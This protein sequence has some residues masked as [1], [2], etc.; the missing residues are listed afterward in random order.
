MDRKTLIGKLK[1]RGELWNEPGGGEWGTEECW[2]AFIR[3]ALE[4]WNGFCAFLTEEA[5]AREMV[6]LS[7]VIFELVEKLGKERVLVPFKKVAEKY[8]TEAEKYNILR[9]ISC[10]ESDDY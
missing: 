10:I 6:Y 3:I 8:P 9:D 1:Y 5:T 4:D 2:N 7:E